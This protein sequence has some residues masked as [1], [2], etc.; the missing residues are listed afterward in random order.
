MIATFSILSG[1]VKQSD[2]SENPKAFKELLVDIKI[3]SPSYRDLFTKCETIKLESNTQSLFGSIDKIYCFGDSLILLDMYRSTVSLFDS[4]GHFLNHIGTIGNGPEEY[5]MCYD[6]AVNPQTGT[7][8]LMAPQ[9][10]VADYSF[11]G[12]FIDKWNL[13]VKPNYFACEWIDSSNLA[14]W[15]IVNIDES[16]V[17]AYNINL[18]KNLYEDWHNDRMLDMNRMKPFYHYNNTVKFSG[19]LSN[20]IY[21]LEDSCMSL[22]YKWN[23][24]PENISM[25]YIDEINS[26]EDTSK[27]N[28][29][30][31]NDTKNGILK[32]IPSFNGETDRYYYVALQTGIGDESIVK[33]V[34]Y[35]KKTDESIVFIKFS[36]GMSFRPIFMNEE[37]ALCQVPYDEIDIY[38]QLLGT[39]LKC[40]DD[41]N[42]V[43]AKFYFKK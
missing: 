13:P 37:Y 16:G 27:K 17:S 12:K 7:V 9:G 6:F 36:E 29:R 4:E 5:L 26:I 35:N 30:I 11:S 43:L 19:P 8:S 22:S 38:N 10:T 34:F 31:I 42:P 18:K 2:N 23:F 3:E 40:S 20:D 32:E 41:E 14:L 28:E 25:S 39:D 24:N 21:S 15:S 33:S 1:C